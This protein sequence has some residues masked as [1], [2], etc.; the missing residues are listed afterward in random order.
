MGSGANARH[1]LSKE[2]SSD[3]GS[4]DGDF[5]RGA[6]PLA[7]L[8]QEQIHAIEIDNSMAVV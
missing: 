4:I 5:L 1:Q 2:H 8:F 7:S 6:V 3:L